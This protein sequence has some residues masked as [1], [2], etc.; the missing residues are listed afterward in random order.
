MPKG[1][2]PFLYR[3]LH[4]SLTDEQ[5]CQLVAMRD[6]QG[7]EAAENHYNV[8]PKV[9]QKISEKVKSRPD[10]DRVYWQYRNSI[11]RRWVNGLGETLNAVLCKISETVQTS[12]IDL[13]KLRELTRTIEVLGDIGVSVTA[14]APEAIE[15]ETPRF[16]IID[17]ELEAEEEE[18]QLLLEGAI[19]AA[20]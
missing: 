14:I 10:L 5:C 19:D 15:Q 7:V 3:K 12:E 13:L 6:V 4:T 20:S 16:E 11:A 2:D 17:A 18:E 1:K 8:P 9:Q